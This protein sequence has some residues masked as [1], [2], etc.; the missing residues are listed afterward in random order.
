AAKPRPFISHSE[1]EE[2]ASSDE[3]L[4]PTEIDKSF[5]E[6][7][8]NIRERKADASVTPRGSARNSPDATPKCSPMMPRKRDDESASAKTKES[9]AALKPVTSAMEDYTR[10]DSL[11]ASDANEKKKSPTP[12]GE[13]GTM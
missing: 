6:Q 9:A 7:L 8:R 11:S 12:S 1:A 10:R 13:I 3:E 2:E 5:A 4:S